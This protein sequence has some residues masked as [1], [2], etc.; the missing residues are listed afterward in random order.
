MNFR[1]GHFLDFSTQVLAR[2]CTRPVLVDFG[3]PWCGPCRLLGPILDQLATEA[4]GRWELVKVNLDEHPG[5]AEIYQVRSIP[6]VRL[7]RDGLPVARLLGG[8]PEDAIRRWLDRHVA[9]ANA[10][11]PPA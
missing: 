6:D 2:S 11:P 10:S 8:H 3:A 9:T 4:G 1:E 5:L 7:F